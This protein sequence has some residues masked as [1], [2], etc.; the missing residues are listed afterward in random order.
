MPP[1]MAGLSDAD[2]DQDQDTGAGPDTDMQEDQTTCPVCNGVG[3]VSHDVASQVPPELMAPPE[4]GQQQIGAAGSPP[5]EGV[6]LGG[7]I[8]GGGMKAQAMGGAM[9]TTH[10]PMH[11]PKAPPKLSTTEHKVQDYIKNRP[12]HLQ[13]QPVNVRHTARLGERA[14]KR[15]RE[16]SG[17]E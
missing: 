13:K 12:A 17:R 2:Q 5:A 8:A 16:M 15:F 3:Q 10:A 7:E 14:A 11:H 1:M 4:E 9:K 6:K